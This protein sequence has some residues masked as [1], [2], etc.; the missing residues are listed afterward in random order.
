MNPL[1][2][3]KNSTDNQSVIDQ[4][5][6]VIAGLNTPEE[7]KEKVEDTVPVKATA[8][9]PKTNEEMQTFVLQHS[10]ELVEN[11]VKSI[12]AVSYTHLTLPTIL[13]V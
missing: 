12:M 11:S 9:P 13:R 6:A 8:I 7:S 4:I 5:D 10:A 2:P 1:L 3:D